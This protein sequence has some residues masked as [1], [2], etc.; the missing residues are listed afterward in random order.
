MDLFH[1]AQAK[2]VTAILVVNICS[3]ITIRTLNAITNN[4]YPVAGHATN[5]NILW[6]SRS[7]SHADTRLLI[8]C[9][10]QLG[11]ALLFKGFPFKHCH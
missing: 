9:I 2:C 3:A 6:A 8:Q 1:I 5:R 10:V 7:A 4:R 11:L